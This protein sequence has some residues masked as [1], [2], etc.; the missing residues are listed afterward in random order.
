M[1]ELKRILVASAA[2]APLALA[3]AAYAVTVPSDYAQDV[4]DGNSQVSSDPTAK[5]QQTEVKDGEK[6]EGQVDEGDVQVD[7]TVGD[8]ENSMDGAQ[9]GE[10]SGSTDKNDSASSTQD[11]GTEN[12]SASQTPT[13]GTN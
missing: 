2:M 13:V 4:K 5:A 6:V 12:S 3:S 7:E 8:Q 10:T 1:I 11:S 9:S